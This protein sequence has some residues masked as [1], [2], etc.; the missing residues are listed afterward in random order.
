M[1]F[2][3]L[4]AD[5]TTP[6]SFEEAAQAVD[7]LFRVPSDKRILSHLYHG[8]FS[9]QG[10]LKKRLAPWVGSGV[11]QRWFNGER[12][13]QAYDALSLE[14]HLFAFE[15]TDVQTSP[16]TAAA[17]T[18]YLMHRIRT[19]LRASAS[20]H[21]IFIDEAAP[22]LKHAL[23]REA[24]EVL[25][26]EHRKLR[27]SITVC[28][29]TVG[30]VV[31]TGIASVILEQCPTRFL[32]PNPSAK[33]EE[34]ALFHLSD[35]EWAYITGESRLSR[36]LKHSVLLKRPHDSVILNIDMSPLGPYLKLYRSG[37]EAVKLV[38]TLQ[39]TWGPQWI[40]PYLTT[41]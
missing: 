21:L 19:T 2:L 24:V 23:F 1:Q 3:Q 30:D 35:T 18:H 32:F 12:E 39:H 5:T 13:G 11:Y 37:V 33:R 40:D 16:L 17:L 15:M 8:L 29:Q 31:K 28:F 38:A 10:V 27:G 36:T 22:M 14:G 41:A 26:K 20:P 9:P 4:L 25:F 34:Y 6:E 7:I